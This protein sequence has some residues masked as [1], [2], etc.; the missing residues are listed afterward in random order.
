MFDSIIKDVNEKYDLGDKA[1]ALVSAILALMT[2]KGNGGFA[3]FID[4]FRATG[5]G[6]LAD[7]WISSGANTPVSYE[8]LESALGEDTL[9][10]ISEQVGTDYETTVNASEYVI[11]HLVDDL[12]PNG[13][14]PNESDLLSQVGGYS[15][16]VGTSSGDN[17][18]AADDGVGTSSGGVGTSSGGVGTSSGG[19]G[20]SSGVAGENIDRVDPAAE[21]TDK[22]E[23][24]G[25]PGIF[26][27][28]DESEENPLLAWLLPLLI[29][30]FLVVI[31]FWFCGGN[32]APVAAP[33]AN[34][35]AAN[36]NGN[37][38]SAK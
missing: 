35:N 9:R 25:V 5:L 22:T 11:P 32:S 10:G 23:V 2:D 18:T 17:E 37:T 7:S 1:G 28:K 3:G 12:T 15:T 29:L 30:V 8:Q 13:E 36:I 34:V 31:G 14:I 27:D 16:G 20:T 4:R 6:D 33:E 26:G 21:L 24:A 19:V 38:N